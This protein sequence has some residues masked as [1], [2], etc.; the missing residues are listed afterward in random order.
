MHGPAAGVAGPR[1]QALALPSHVNAFTVL[2]LLQQV[3]KQGKLDD[4][5]KQKLAADIARIE[6]CH[7]DRAQDA[8]LDLEAVARDWLRHAS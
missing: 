1:K 5:Q 6:A 3:G 4:G 2:A 8:T 7:F